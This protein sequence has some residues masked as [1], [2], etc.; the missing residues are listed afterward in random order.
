M[1]WEPE[2]YCDIG[3]P[4]FTKY[5]YIEN[6]GDYVRWRRMVWANKVEDCLYPDLPRNKYDYYRYLNARRLVK[7]FYKAG[8][9][10]MLLEDVTNGKVPDGYC[11]KQIEGFGRW[12]SKYPS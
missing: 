11:G 3:L 8:K 5:L 6:R 12:Y 9:L 4:P 7:R 10:D 1:D 2:K